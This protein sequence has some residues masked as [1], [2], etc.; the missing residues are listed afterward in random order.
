V[1]FWLLRIVV[2]VHALGVFAQ[3]VLAG[4]FLSGY[5]DFVEIHGRVGELVEVVGLIQVLIAI[6]VRW[7][8]RGPSWPIWVSLA[9]VLAEVPQVFLG[10]TGALALH[11]PLGVL[12]FAAMLL[13][14]IRLW[15]PVAA[16]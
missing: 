3:P 11:V 13:L 4:Q 7:P 6:L 12:L 8:G 9:V 16:Q 15:R 14:L 2:T 5:F 1:L 10:Y